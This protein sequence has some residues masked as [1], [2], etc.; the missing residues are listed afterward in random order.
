MQ[1]FFFKP[2]GPLFAALLAIFGF[3]TRPM[4]KCHAVDALLDG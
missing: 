1:F 3:S 4:M 2:F